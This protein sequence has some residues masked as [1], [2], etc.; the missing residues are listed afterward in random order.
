MPTTHKGERVALRLTSENKRSIMRAAH[1]RG[2][3]VTDFMVWSSLKAAD[4]VLQEHTRINL[5]PRDFKRFTEALEADA[6][7]SDVLREAAEEYKTGQE[8]DGR[9]R[10]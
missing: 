6:Q 1:L 2:V 7:P 4:E 10:W 3:S 9:Y 5:S 8:E